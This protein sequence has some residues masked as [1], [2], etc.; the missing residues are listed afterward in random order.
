MA[1]TQLSEVIIP[2]EFT[3][4]QVDNS[5]VSTALLQSGV[6]ANN[7]LIA[8]QLQAGS[9]SFNVPFWNDLPDVEADLTNDD[10]TDLSTPQKVGA[11]K[12]SVR[13]SFLHALRSEMSLASELSGSLA[14]QRIQD[15]VCAYWSRQWEKRIIATLLGV[16]ASNVAN[17]ASDMVVD[18]SGSAGAAASRHDYR[19]AG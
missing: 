18:I 11:S 12:Q 13:K 3:A 1:Q 7:A 19:S 15:R 10:P 16:L 14:L 6:V 9:E 5:L 8:A 4:Y 2:D 17:N